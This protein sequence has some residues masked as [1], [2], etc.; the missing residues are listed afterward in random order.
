M[1]DIFQSSCEI[2]VRYLK[3]V[4]KRNATEYSICSFDSRSRILDK[5]LNNLNI[6]CSKPKN[7][8][9]FKYFFQIQAP[10]TVQIQAPKQISRLLTKL[11]C[12]IWFCF[13]IRQLFSE[14]YLEHSQTSPMELFCKNV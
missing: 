3:F 7:Q 13:E 1:H 4:R 10:N 9:Q 6:Y 5:I 11:V 2:E 8:I 14:A 12:N